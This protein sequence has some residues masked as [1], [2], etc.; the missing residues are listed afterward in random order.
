VPRMSL[1]AV[2][3]LAMAG[4]VVLVLVALWRS[5]A[6]L[7]IKLTF[8]GYAALA[9]VITHYLGGDWAFMRAL[10]ELWMVGG[11]IL[12][13]ARHRSVALLAPATLVSW[14]TLALVT[15]LYR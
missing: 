5:R 8:L 10:A 3:L 7:H 9:V 11:A 4:F 1:M 12:L 6:S 2:E 13:A 14:C 15:I